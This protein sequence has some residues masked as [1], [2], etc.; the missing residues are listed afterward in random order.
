MLKTAILFLV[1]GLASSSNICP[2]GSSCPDSST[3]CYSDTGYKCCPYPDAVCCVDHIHCCPQGLTC[4]MIEMTCDGHGAEPGIPMVKKI[5]AAEQDAFLPVMMGKPDANVE[6]SKVQCDSTHFCPDGNTCCRHPYGIWKCCPLS[7]AVCCLD[8]LHCCP[9]GYYCDETYTK[10]LR[11]GLSIPSFL[12]RP[13]LTVKS[14]NMTTSAA[15]VL[16]DEG[17]EEKLPWVKLQKA[18]TS[19]SKS[20][21]IRCD[22][23]YYCPE[24]T[25][26]CKKAD[27]IWSCCPFPLAQCCQDRLHCCPYSYTCDG[28]STMCVKNNQRI[29]SAEKEDAQWD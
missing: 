14:S 5:P 3:C 16:R 28:S 12:K 9:F 13:A 27:N 29:P 7:P 10:C 4:N 6:S 11:N 8:G 20:S 22:G 19:L 1:V 18:V 15:Q 23:V 2:D 24:N 25:T 21:V 26:C 17:T